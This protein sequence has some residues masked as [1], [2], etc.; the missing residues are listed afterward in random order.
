MSQLKLGIPKG[1]LENATVELFDQAGWKISSRT[2][3]YFPTIDDPELT[4]TLVRSQEM[5]RYVASGTLDAGL[6]GTD[7]IAET[8]ADVEVVSDLIY[9]KASDQPCRW[10]LIVKENSPITCIKDLEGKTI[11]T[12]LVDYTKSF[13]AKNNISANVEYS[14]G[15]TEAKVVEDLADAA[16]EITETGNTIRAHGLRIVCDLMNTHTVLVANKISFA[17]EWKK[18]KIEQISLMLQ[19]A[20]AARH[21]VLLK[22]NVPSNSVEKVT[23]QL[24]SLHSPTINTMTDPDWFAL[25]AVVERKEIRSLIPKLKEAGAQG[26][27]EIALKHIS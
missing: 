2:R 24:P 13:L 14:W 26:I 10:V 3:N 21:K 6:C 25:E 18:S 15:A 20:L 1:S 19:S 16:V 4:C 27:L 11:A 12:E 17:D 7:W 5:G 22:M 8:N 23:N 9:S